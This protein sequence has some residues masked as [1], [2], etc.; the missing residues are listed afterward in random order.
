MKIFGLTI[1]SREQRKTFNEL[2]RMNDREL[3][4]IGISRCDIRRLVDSMDI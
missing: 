1:W 4:D 3:N 2:C